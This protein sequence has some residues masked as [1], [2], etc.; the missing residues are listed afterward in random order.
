MIHR[1]LTSDHRRKKANEER[2]D[3]VEKIENDRCPQTKKPIS[4]L[5]SAIV[6]NQP[7]LTRES[8]G[9]I[10]MKTSFSPRELTLAQKVALQKAK[11]ERSASIRQV[12][13]RNAMT[14]NNSLGHNTSGNTTT[15]NPTTGSSG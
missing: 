13:N 14:R 10:R 1:M 4:S 2:H 5:K 11:E 9:N 12:L 7:R 3:L 8:K 15:G 6:S